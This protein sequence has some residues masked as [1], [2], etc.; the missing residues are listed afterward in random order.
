[1]TITVEE[2]QRSVKLKNLEYAVSEAANYN[3]QSTDRLI[4]ALQNLANFLDKKVEGLC[5]VD[6]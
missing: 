1:M 2:I 5:I 6:K 4:K 3:D